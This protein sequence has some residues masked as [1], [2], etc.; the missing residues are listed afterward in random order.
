[1]K[2]EKNSTKKDIIF[3][4]LICLCVAVMIFS[5]YMVF[6][7]LHERTLDADEFEEIRSIVSTEIS[8][9]QSAF[10]DVTQNEEKV[11]YSRDVSAA[12]A[13]NSECVGW[14]YISGTVIDYPVMHTPSEP[15]KYLHLSFSGRESASGVPFMDGANRPG[16]ENVFIYGHNMKNGTMFHAL[17]KYFDKSFYAN[18]QTVEFETAEGVNYYNV[19]AVVETAEDDEWYSFLETEDESEFDKKIS[20]IKSKSKYD[21]GITPKKGDKLLTLSTCLNGTN[22]GRVLI[23]CVK[24]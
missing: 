24:E 18:H 20:Y 22:E 5:G 6:G 15:Q 11:P 3:K 2:K 12:L 13:K 9:S 1:M 17:K 8:S 10:D 19:F 4:V 21:T 7:E 23:V 16:D 14:I